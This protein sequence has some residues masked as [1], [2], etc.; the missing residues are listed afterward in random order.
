MDGETEAQR[1]RVLSSRSLGWDRADL[2]HV[3]QFEGLVLDPA[4][5]SVRGRGG[6]R[7]KGEL[8]LVIMLEDQTCIHF[9]SH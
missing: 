4:P 7:V 2:E 1:Q 5:P 6:L 8:Q 3:A 9:F